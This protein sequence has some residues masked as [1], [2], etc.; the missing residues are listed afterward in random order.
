MSRQSNIAHPRSYIL[1]W[2]TM[3]QRTHRVPPKA[4]QRLSEWLE[5]GALP[6]EDAALVLSVFGE[7][8]AQQTRPLV[9]RFLTHKNPYLREHALSALILDWG[10]K[11]HRITCIQMMQEDPDE[12]VRR[13]AATCLG[14]LDR[15][16]HNPE[17]L[18][19]LI[20]VF[21]NEAEEKY[22]REMAYLSI[23]DVIAIPWK[24]RPSAAREWNWA[25]EIDWKLL[26]ALSQKLRIPFLWPH[27]RD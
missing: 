1:R 4:L 20:N 17:T 22:V 12:D 24:D 6:F 18:Q 19:L 10:L 25:T 23:L 3:A 27:K 2:L 7:G 21:Q 13:M 14:S 5:H 8:A 9:E 15:A 16:T 26:Q 11:D